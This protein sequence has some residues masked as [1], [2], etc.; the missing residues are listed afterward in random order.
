MLDVIRLHTKQD[1]SKIP[2]LGKVQVSFW[3]L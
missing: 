3:Y 2:V 1:M